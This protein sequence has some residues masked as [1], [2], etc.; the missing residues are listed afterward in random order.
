MRARLVGVGA[1]NSAVVV[2]LPRC[3]WVPETL[4]RRQCPTEWW[5]LR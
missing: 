3:V 2:D 1:G 5:G 4:S